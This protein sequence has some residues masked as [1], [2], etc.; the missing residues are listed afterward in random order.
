[1]NAPVT[2]I[3]VGD[4]YRPHPAFESSTTYTQGEWS[5]KLTGIWENLKL[6]QNQIVK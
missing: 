3:A 5:T 1:M 6:L 4:N 2:S